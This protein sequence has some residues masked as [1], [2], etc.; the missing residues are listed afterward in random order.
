VDC[1]RFKAHAT[2]RSHKKIITAEA[3]LL[4]KRSVRNSGGHAEIRPVILTTVMAGEKSWPI[5]LTLTDRN[6][7]GFRML[8]GRQAVRQRFLVDSGR[9]YLQT[10]KPTQ[11]LKGQKKSKKKSKSK[12]KKAQ[13]FKKNPQ[14]GS[15]S[16]P[17]PTQHEDSSPVEKPVSLFNPPS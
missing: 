11:K 3:P 1:V 13:K 6:L 12:A 14:L 4:D 8:L 17:S 7:M 16:T 5:E 2:Q 15:P 10:T 9:S